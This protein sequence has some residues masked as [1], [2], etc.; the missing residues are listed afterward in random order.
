[1]IHL[2]A[3][4]VAMQLSG[5]ALDLP[6]LLGGGIAYVFVVA[7]AATSNDRAIRAL[8]LA[9]WR[10]LHATGGWLLATIFSLTYMGGLANK[11]IFS[12]LALAG[13]GGVV[14]L[15]LARAVCHKAKAAA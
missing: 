15:K 6:H 13:L 11:P 10:K 4:A 9:N 8:G 2:A 7:M 1:L 3:L 5:R 14:A 12:A